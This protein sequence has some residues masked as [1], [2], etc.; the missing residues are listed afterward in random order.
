MF[1]TDKP[2]ESCKK[3]PKIERN[4]LSITKKKLLERKRNH[5]TSAKTNAP[6]SRTSS[7]CLKLK[8]QTYRMINEE[9]K[10]KLEQLQEE[11]SIAP[12]PLSADL[13]NDFKSIILKADQIKISFFM[14][15][16]WEEQQ[17]CLQPSQNIAT[18]H[19]MNTDADVTYQI[20]N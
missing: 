11:I 5:D 20:V 1:L 10:M 18:Y 9:F 4:A 13:S 7:E 6:I 2:N 8:I 12:L 16:F 19:S 14:R 15:L 17:K 3:P